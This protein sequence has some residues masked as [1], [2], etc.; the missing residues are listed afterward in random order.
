MNS[1]NLKKHKRL[2]IIAC[3]AFIFGIGGIMEISNCFI[4]TDAIDAVV[5]K[6]YQG[7]RTGRRGRSKSRT[8][9]MYVEWTDLNGN[10]HTNRIVF[11]REHSQVG[12][13]CQILVDAKTHSKIISHKP[14]SIVVAIYG[15]FF[16]ILGLW[17]MIMCF[18][19]DTISI[20]KKTPRNSIKH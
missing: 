3:I 2:F 10:S 12:D 8:R 16:C 13:I 5:V 19:Y 17:L 14:E 18:K 9:L 11:D 4:K 1:H 6:A 20:F 7:R 15:A